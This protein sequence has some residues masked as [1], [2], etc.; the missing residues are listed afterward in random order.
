MPG[1][2]GTGPWGQ[3]PL[4]GG[5]RGHCTGA[6]QPPARG[7]GRGWRNHCYATGLAGWER[8]AQAR[9]AAAAPAG[10]VSARLERVEDTL[11]RVLEQ[12]ERTAPGGR[13]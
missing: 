7:A 12:L 6:V 2:D 8:A 9:G 13:A 10:D 1:F 5:R 3:G 4:T 11:A